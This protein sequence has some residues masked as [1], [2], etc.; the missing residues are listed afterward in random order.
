MYDR[1]VRRRRAVLA[2][3]VA[4]SLILLTA[5]FGESSGGGLHSVQRGA[6]QVLGPIQEGA[7]RALKPFRDLFGWAGDTFEAKDERD[8]LKAENERLQRENTGLQAAGIENKELRQL[9]ELDINADLERYE[10]VRARITGRNP[11]IFYSRITIDKGSSAGL[12]VD[13]PVITGLGLV[14][15]VTTVAGNYSIVTLITDRD[16]AAAARTLPSNQQGTVRATGS[17]NSNALELELVEDPKRVRKG[18]RVV[19]AGSLDLKLKSYYPR[20]L[21]IGFVREIE[22]GAGDLDRI[23]RVQPAAELASMVWVEVLTDVRAGTAQADST[24]SP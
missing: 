5:Y 16:F 7:S 8:K 14:G 24:T 13:Q 17:G 10:P 15:R 18:D 21:T 3:L 11:N 19:T 23:I 20:D 1:Q 12:R 2:A 9:N 4:L 6:L 22:L